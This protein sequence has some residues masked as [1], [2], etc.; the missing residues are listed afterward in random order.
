MR[1]VIQRVTQSAVSVSD[2][3]VGKIGKGLLVLL[4]VEKNDTERSAEYLANKIVNL[5]IFEDENGK[6]NTSL[7][8]TGGQM[9]VVSQ[10][11][12]YGDCQKGRRPSFVQAAEPEK[13]K[14]LYEHFA[15]L[16]S[17]KGIRVERG[18]FQETMA[19]SLTNDGPVTLIIESK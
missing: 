19:V 10:F 3:I 18:R 7:M 4:G 12:L 13:A 14:Q 16:V 6:M 1:C 9:L 8:E 17:K 11:T 5:R 15:D 2:K